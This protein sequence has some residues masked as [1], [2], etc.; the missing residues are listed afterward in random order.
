ATYGGTVTLG[1]A[2]AWQRRALPLVWRTW[3]WAVEEPGQDWATALRE[4]AL[5]V[6]AALPRDTQVVVLADRGLSGAPFVRRWQALGWHFLLRV[7]RRTRVAQAGG[8]IR[9]SGALAPTP[10]SQCCLRAVTLYA[11]RRK[12]HGHWETDWTAGVVLQVVAVWRRA[13][14]AAWL[15]VT[16]RPAT[17]ARC[18]E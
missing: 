17:L 6:Q 13:E 11:P 3:A 18:R 8:E 5:V 15:L 4:M 10:G 12:G 2:L 9:E 14:E 16:D 7:T 1:F